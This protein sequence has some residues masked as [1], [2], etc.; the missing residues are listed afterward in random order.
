MEFGAK[1]KIKK[2][3]VCKISGQRAEHLD[4]PRNLD[5]SEKVKQISY[6]IYYQFRNI[7]TYFIVLIPPIP[8]TKMGRVGGEAKFFCLRRI[9][10][11]HL[12]SKDRN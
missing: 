7:F 8:S 11:E 10:N 6:K 3:E 5:L 12:L 1:K 2:K 4:Y 9:E